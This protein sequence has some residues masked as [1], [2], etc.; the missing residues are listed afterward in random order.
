MQRTKD[1]PFT[2]TNQI[3]QRSFKL[4]LLTLYLYPS[5]LAHLRVY[6]HVPMY[7]FACTGVEVNHLS[8]PP[9]THSHPYTVL[10]FI[11]NPVPHV[12]LHPLSLHFFFS[13]LFFPFT[14]SIFLT[15]YVFKCAPYTLLC[16]LSSY[17]LES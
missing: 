6:M 16:T 8:H 12:G 3:P 4:P 10:S 17:C 13:S 11:F 14:S 2:S 9:S 15:S 1:C 7:L 5:P